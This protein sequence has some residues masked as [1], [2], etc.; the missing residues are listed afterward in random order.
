MIL[1]K[2]ENKEAASIDNEESSHTSRK[3]KN[4][5]SNDLVCFGVF[6][7]FKMLYI[8]GKSVKIQPVD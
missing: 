2:G 8:T 5:E 6:T 4:K 3:T 7:N 1:I